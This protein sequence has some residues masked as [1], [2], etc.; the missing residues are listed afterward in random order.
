[1]NTQR[2]L[3]LLIAPQEMSLEKMFAHIMRSPTDIN[4][5]GEDNEGPD[6]HVFNRK[7][8]SNKVFTRYGGAAT[9]VEK[10][11]TRIRTDE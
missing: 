4:Q 1:M 10:E 5:N 3:D 2:L 8:A 9:A 11:K 7:M 6:L